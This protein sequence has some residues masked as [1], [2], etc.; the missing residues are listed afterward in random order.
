MTPASASSV[1]FVRMTRARARRGAH[2]ET[3]RERQQ[4][5]GRK[6]APREPGRDRFVTVE[7][8][9]AQHER[10]RALPA[11]AFA[12]PPQ[13]SAARMDPDIEEPR[14]EAR[15]RRREHDVAGERQV[16]ARA[17]RRARDHCDGRDRRRGDAE[18]PGVRAAEVDVGTI[19]IVE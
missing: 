12:Q 7:R 6:A 2:G 8:V 14:V 11:D 15:V 18:E 10:G 4:V 17:D 9:A 19:E 1:A 3:V 16:H 13:V 5:V